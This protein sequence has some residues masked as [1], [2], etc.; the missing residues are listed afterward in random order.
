MER[1]QNV[2]TAVPPTP[3]EARAASTEWR[4]VGLFKRLT[5]TSDP[6]PPGGGS[7]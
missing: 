4:R 1:K 2:V 3:A 6:T 7:A 5:R